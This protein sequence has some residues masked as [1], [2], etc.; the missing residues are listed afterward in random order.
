MYTKQMKGIAELLAMVADREGL[1]SFETIPVVMDAFNKNHRYHLKQ[2]HKKFEDDDEARW[3]KG[4][5]S[6][7]RRGYTDT[8]RGRYSRSR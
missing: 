2:L 6:Y 7:R 5:R 8:V 4:R 1:T 3:E